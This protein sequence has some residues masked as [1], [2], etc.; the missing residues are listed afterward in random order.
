MK[1]ACKYLLLFIFICTIAGIG[2]TAEKDTI[3]YVTNTGER[4]H[5]EQCSSVRNSKIEI[6]LEDAVKRGYEPCG[7][8]KPPVLNDDE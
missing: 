7:R 1:K 6:S 4:Y 2:Y 3:V 5:T 8:C